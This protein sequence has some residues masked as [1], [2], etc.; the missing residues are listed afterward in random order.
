MESIFRFIAPPSRCGYLPQQTWRLEYEQVAEI[1]PAEYMERMRDGWRRFGDMLFRPHCPRCTACQSIRVLVDRFRPNRS[2]RRTRR[3]NDGTVELRIGTPSVSREKLDLYDRYHANQSEE[4]GWPVHEP[5]DADEYA[6][7]F[8]DNPFATQEWCYYLADRLIGVGYVDDLPGG[9]S[10]IY[11]FYDPEERARTL[12]TW[13]VLRVIDEA[14]LRHIPHVYLGY[15]VAGC[16]SMAY[17]ARF[18]PNQ[19]RGTDGV[20]RDFT[21]ESATERDL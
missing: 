20:W 14:R 5:K 12:G 6:R 17:K 16:R 8:V 10:A 13:N 15:Y 19:V 3:L 9:L 1:N 4:K 18:V 11:F 7:S 21:P 2:Q